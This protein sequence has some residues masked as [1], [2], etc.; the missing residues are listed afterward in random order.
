MRIKIELIGDSCNLCIEPNIKF[1]DHKEAISFVKHTNNQGKL[2][3]SGACW[4][5]DI[6]VEFFH[7]DLKPMGYYATIQR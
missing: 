3:E 5:K 4:I 2:I 6:E 7:N 1:A